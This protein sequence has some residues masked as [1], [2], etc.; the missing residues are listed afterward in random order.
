MKLG[1]NNYGIKKFGAAQY[2]QQ[3]KEMLVFKERGKTKEI[4]KFFIIQ[5]PLSVRL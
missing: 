2:K 1:G 4:K 5:E 3:E